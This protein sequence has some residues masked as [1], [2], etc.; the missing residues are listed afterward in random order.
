MAF[1]TR[2]IHFSEITFLKRN[3]SN[4][5]FEEVPAINIFKEI[6]S[7]QFLDDESDQSRYLGLDSGDRVCLQMDSLE[8]PIRGRIGR[9][10]LT[11]LPS[12]EYEGD[13]S[14][15]ALSP[16]RG[17]FESCHFVLYP[18]KVIGY[19][20]NAFGPRIS[21]LCSYLEEKAKDQVDYVLYKLLWNSDVAGKLQEVESVTLFSISAHRDTAEAISR[22]DDNLGRVFRTARELSPAPVIK[23]DLKVEKHRRHGF[24][25]PWLEHMPSMLSDNDVRHGVEDL[26]IRA[27]NFDETRAR[28]LD[29]LEDALI[30]TKSVVQEDDQHRSVSSESMY[31]AIYEAR[32]ELNPLISTALLP[33][34]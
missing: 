28:K 15:L 7:L 25:I 13:I 9:K 1:A 24:Q 33:Q 5:G 18:D 31:E 6:E 27:K 17:L 2:R 30:A 4:T 21:R 8:L 22:H 23:F 29:L 3:D 14:P 11:N 32:E 12:I 26:W 20:G 10:R 19:E 34:G 16:G